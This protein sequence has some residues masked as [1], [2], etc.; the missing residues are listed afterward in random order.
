MPDITFPDGYVS[1]QR[2]GVNLRPNGYKL[3]LDP[4]FDDIIKDV[5]YGLKNE[6]FENH[7]KG[8]WYD[9][10]DELIE[11]AFESVCR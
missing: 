3:K 8:V 5:A 9:D 7:L 11:Q 6:Q 10:I 2:R 1:H 4:T